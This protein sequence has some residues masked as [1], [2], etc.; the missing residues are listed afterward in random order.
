MPLFNSLKTRIA[1]FGV[2]V[3]LL[4]IVAVGLFFYEEG[5]ARIREVQF[6]H[7]ADIA[8]RVAADLDDRVRT[9][10]QLV[11][12][13]AAGLETTGPVS[14]QQAP[15]L[16]AQLRLLKG[17]FN[18]VVLYGPDG[19][20]LADYPHLP[21]RAG[22][23][24]ADRPYFL[25]TRAT[26]K[27]QISPPLR[28]RG[29]LNRS[30][31]VFTA[32]VRDAAG[33]FAGMVGATLEL[34]SPEFFDDLRRL[35]VG[36]SGYITLTSIGSELT[37]YHPNPRLVMKPVPGPQASPALHRALN[38]WRGAT[39]TVNSSGRQ[40]L[41]AF[42]PLNSVDWL[43]GAVLPVEEAY[44]PIRA[45]LRDYLL[46]AALAVLA[47]LPLMWW[48]M[49]RMLR[50]LDVLRA[51][52]RAVKLRTA[53]LP[54]QIEG[55]EELTA[56]AGELSQVFEEREA[57]EARL[58]EREAFFRTL[59]DASPLGVLVIEPDGTVAYLNQAALQ[60][61]GGGQPAQWRGQPWI[62]LVHPE[63]RAGV[64][65]LARTA[66]E[67]RHSLTLYCR[68]ARTEP[69]A[70]QVELRLHPLAEDGSA[71]SLLVLT[72]I[73]ERE[74]TKRALLAE[75][76][77]AMAILGSIADAVVLTNHLDEVHYLNAPAEHLLGTVQAEAFG[78]PLA[79]LARFLQPETGLE[80][81]LRR[82]ELQGR[83]H[84]L[85]LDLLPAAGPAVPV[86][87]TLSV[88]AMPGA[89]EGYRV[90]VLHDDAERR[91]R[92]RLHRWE[93][94]HDALTGL[95]NR[96]GFHDALASLLDRPDR[97]ARPHALAMFDL[98]HF[99]TVNDNAGH[100][101]G[102]RLLQA[103]ALV[104]QQRIRT[105]DAAARLGGD[106]F[107]VLLYNCDLG[108]ATAVMEDIRRQIGALEVACNGNRYQVSASIGLT[109]LGKDDALPE[110]AIARADEL[111][112]RAKHAGR[113]RVETTHET[114]A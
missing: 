19:V 87:L 102:D 27:P 39:E 92:E 48:R 3:G 59:N 55:Y 38:G 57:F 73:T 51:Q 95:Y 1:L 81:F 15:G 25:Q 29:N 83:L 44:A 100:L 40:V 58:A 35:R 12:A 79:R 76:E 96:R 56:M 64:E 4:L 101:S 47:V 53:R 42:R 21:G 66:Q 13:A 33:R 16:L 23:S 9:R 68:I 65:D 88:V 89:T 45:L 94:C 85:E 31:V 111:C 113:N 106:E 112:Y 26:L 5:R 74:A 108:H 109:L 80:V 18:S 86:E 78:Q 69:P 72:D 97:G 99:K 52:V 71:R 20:I 28:A 84:H 67:G 62:R 82:L 77:R 17:A 107:A 54:L 11:A 46:L 63:D 22:L 41:V 105:S 103:V 49:R 98:D 90:Y 6:R 32:P 75:R 91:Q 24:V 36:Q 104:V 61:A 34:H 110:Q 114:G 50:P 43:V 14:A 30:I 37:I 2:F 10:R 8:D 7:L 60:L 70:L 93:A